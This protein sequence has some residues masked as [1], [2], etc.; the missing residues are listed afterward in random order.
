MRGDLLR[1]GDAQRVDD[2]GH[3]L[4]AGRRGSVEPVDRAVHLIAEVVI[5][6]HDEVAGQPVQAGPLDLAALQH[7]DGV[8]WTGDCPRDLDGVDTRE[9]PVGHGYG[10]AIDHADRTAER[11]QGMC[12][13]HLRPDGVTVGSR[14]RREHERLTGEQRGGNRRSRH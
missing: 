4:R 11:P 13:R 6:V 8:G 5:D 2:V 10:I 12:Q 3:H 7:D 9:R 1:P 14:V